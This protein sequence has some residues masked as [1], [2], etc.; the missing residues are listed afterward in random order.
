MWFFVFLTLGLFAALAIGERLLPGRALP[1][2]PLWRLK[3]I[4]FLLLSAALSVALP[5]LW[6]GWLGSHRLLDGTKLGTW[7]GA[8]VG[9]LALEFVAYWWHRAAHR[10]NFLWRHAHQMHHSA[11]RLDVYGAYLFHPLD[12]AGF[13]FAYSLG[14]VLVVGVTAEAA[15]LAGGLVTFLSLF[16]H[17]NIRTPHWLGYIVQRPESHG[18]HHQRGVHAYNYADLPLWDIIFGTFRNPRAWDEEVGLGAGA[19]RRL[20]ALLLGRD[21][22]LPTSSAVPVTAP[23][24]PYPRRAR[25]TG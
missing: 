2:V 25:I 24:A 21:V 3:G 11:E 16:Q 1:A 17:T 18:I 22:S 7:G 8:L 15:M 14:L 6:D 13:S 9:F 4:F 10:I 23:A 12:I 19:S 20:G 5:L